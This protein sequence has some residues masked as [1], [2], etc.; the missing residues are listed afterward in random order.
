MG[1]IIAKLPLDSVELK[2]PERRVAGG[3]QCGRREVAQ[4]QGMQPR[5]APVDFG[6]RQGCRT[7]IG[8]RRA[9][10][11]LS[12]VWAQSGEGY[13]GQ[14]AGV[15]LEVKDGTSGKVRVQEI[16]ELVNIRIERRR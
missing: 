11:Y 9:D 8:M 5:Y 4:N 13:D 15:Y 7:Y 2:V 3:E 6:K 14:P 12:K 16:R 1:P 10:V